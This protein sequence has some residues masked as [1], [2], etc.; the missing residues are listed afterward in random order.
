MAID[1]IYILNYITN[2]DSNTKFQFFISG[3]GFIL[4]L[5]HFLNFNSAHYRIDS[6]RKISEYIISG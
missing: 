2:I 5:K 4:F 6:T 1:T 3:K